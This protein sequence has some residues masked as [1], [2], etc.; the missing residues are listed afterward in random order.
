MFDLSIVIPTCNRSESLA[1]CL[2]SIRNTTQCQYE[3]IVVDGAS[4]DATASVLQRGAE[5][6]GNR[7]SVIREP[8]REGFVKAANK[9]FRAARGRYVMWL[10][11][12][13]RPLDHALDRAVEQIAFTPRT[14]GMVALFHSAHT[15]RNVAF[16][17]HHLGRDFHLLHVR[18][19]L[20]A[21]F[22]IAARTL[23]ERLGYF[24]ER[25]FL[26][27]AD[28]DFSLKIWNAGL[29]VVPAFGALIDHDEIDDP[30]RQGDLARADE[31]DAKLFA[32][33]DLPEKKLNG[34]DFNQT[35]PCT[36]RG[37]RSAR[38]A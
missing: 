9:G 33:W 12:D 30:R 25:F 29:S 37:L 35:R 6:F 11:D 16:E 2:V 1:S 7:L 18:G 17:A 20:Y 15:D 4:T 28:P 8:Q 5:T 38:A 36:L 14:V 27:G 21:N 32:K 19:T 24:D 23:W 13:A 34:T 26:N 10:N 22:G 3:L 31:D